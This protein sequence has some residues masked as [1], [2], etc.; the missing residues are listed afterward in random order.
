MF[1]PLQVVLQSADGSE[2]GAPWLEMQ[3]YLMAPSSHH[4]AMGLAWNLT[5]QEAL[6][7]AGA[8]HVDLHTGAQLCPLVR[9]VLYI[10]Y[11]K[12]SGA[13]GPEEPGSW[14]QG[15]GLDTGQD[16]P[17]LAMKFAATSFPSLHLPRP[18]TLTDLAVTISSMHIGTRSCACV[19]SSPFLMKKLRLRWG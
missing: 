10:A 5:L 16:P 1:D 9:T 11:P 4:S 8:R 15:P 19:M 18:L 17:C 6:T 7:L 14:W 3:P 2:Q 13:P 12:E